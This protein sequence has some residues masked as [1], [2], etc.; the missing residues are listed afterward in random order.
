MAAA[1]M[2][3]LPSR[4]EGMPNVVLEAMAAGKPVIA[5]QAEG[6]VELLGLA[7]W[8]KPWPS[9]TG[10]E[11][12]R[13]SSA[14]RKTRVSAR[15]SVAE[16]RDAQQFLWSLSHNVMGDFTNLCVCDDAKIFFGAVSITLRENWL[17]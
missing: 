3:L 10:A 7:R 13:G 4:W 14:L 17:R 5:T 9:A 11:S 8:S 15:N 12:G 16:I 2:L 1:D 6:T